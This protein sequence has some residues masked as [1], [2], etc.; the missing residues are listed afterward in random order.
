MT[1]VQIIAALV[2]NSIG[3]LLH[4]ID[5]EPRS[6]AHGSKTHG[7]HIYISIAGSQALGQTCKR[8]VFASE[9][10]GGENQVCGSG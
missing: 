10:T 9:T 4:L 1:K 5:E 8:L 6:D 3:Q 7:G 2:W